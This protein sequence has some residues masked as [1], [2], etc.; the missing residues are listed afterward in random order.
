MVALTSGLAQGAVPE[1]APPD[2]RV[3]IDISGSM[4]QNDPRNLRR[5]ALRL[6]VGLLPEDARAGVWT[7]GQYVN[8]QV[9]LG[10]VDTGWKGRAR[11]GASKIHR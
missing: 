7:F 9:P 1:V 5:P 4:K 6:L 2:V 11:E 3:L 8:M 10:K